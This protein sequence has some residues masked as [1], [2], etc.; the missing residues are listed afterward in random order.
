MISSIVKGLCDGVVA[1]AE[2]AFVF[3]RWLRHRIHTLNVVSRWFMVVSRWCRGGSWWCRDG[4]WW[5]AVVCGGLWWFT[6]VSRWFMVVS[7]WFMV[8]R[9]RVAV[10]CGS[11]R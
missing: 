3:G 4:S 8:V 10:V 1:R 9:G 7:R 2:F 5:F 11:S 6:V